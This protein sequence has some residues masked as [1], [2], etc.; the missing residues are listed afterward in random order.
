[1]KRIT[2]LIALTATVATV[3]AQDHEKKEAYRFA[4]KETVETTPVK[5]Q[6]RS[7]TCWTFGTASFIESEL[8]RMNK[9]LYDISEMFFV[10]N[11]YHDHAKSYVRF[12]GKINFTGGAEG[13]DVMNV[14]RKYG[15]V[16][17]KAYRG[18]GYGEEKHVHGEM[19]YLLK[20]YVDAV[21]ENKNKK[22]SP[23]WIKAFDGILD[24]YLGDY[25]YRFDFDGEEYSPTSF[26]D[27]LN[28]NADDY[29]ALTSFIHQPFYESYIF[30]SPDNWSYGSIYNVPLDDLIE[31]ID[32]AIKNG[33][34]VVWSS[35]ISEKG[36]QYRKGIAVVPDEKSEEIDGLEQA[37]WEEMSDR[38]KKKLVYSFEHLVPEKEITP[39]LRQQAFDNYETTDDHLMHI[40]GLAADQHGNKYYKVKNSWGTEGSRF[41]GYFYASEAFVRYKTMSIMLHKEALKKVISKKINIK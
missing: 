9:G 14:V 30:E 40:I 12:H 37:K 34:S 26:R 16:T 17:E 11:A 41:D 19:D 35:D 32:Y 2:F 22:L 3:F 6:Y 18:I 23:V 29:I 38:E 27:K 13:W 7:G 36:F 39:E 8:L 20:T 4:D 15:L 28:F 25:P 1:M 33:Y 5:N 24:A 21:I 31:T 10:R